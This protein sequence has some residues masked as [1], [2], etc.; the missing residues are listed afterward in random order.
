MGS[1][2]YVNV[3]RF[4]NLSSHMSNTERQGGIRQKSKKNFSAVRR[5]LRM[6]V[7]RMVFCNSNAKQFLTVFQFHVNQN[8]FRLPSIRDR[9]MRVSDKKTILTVWNSMDITVSIIDVDSVMFFLKRQN[10]ADSVF[11]F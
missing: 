1:G 7:S 6:W 2:E 10:I 11:Q 3:R 8:N 5:K 9:L 4:Y